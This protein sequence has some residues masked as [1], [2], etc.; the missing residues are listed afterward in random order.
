MRSYTRNCLVAGTA[1]LVVA[2]LPATSAAQGVL[3]VNDNKVGIGIDTPQEPLHVSKDDGTARLLVQEKSGAAGART[4]LVLQNQGPGASKIRINSGSSD[5][6]DFQTQSGGFAFSNI[7]TGGSELFIANDG[8]VRMGGGGASNFQL[9]VSGNLEIAGT[10]TQ[11]SSRA[12]KTAFANVDA[13]QTLEL[14][15]DMQMSVWTYQNDHT[16][17]R[18]IGPMAEDFH[19]AFGLGVD[20]RHIAP[21]DQSGVALVA[22]Q[23]LNSVIE[24]KDREIQ[25]LKARVDALER[26]VTRLSDDR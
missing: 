7:T 15:S 12:V 23:G 16:A 26:L 22:I 5:P 2:L 13:R 9:D 10:L 11:N 14:L 25:D 20:N 8:R 3:F 18:H 21:S 19:A 24:D 17:A 6:W 4:L 1:L